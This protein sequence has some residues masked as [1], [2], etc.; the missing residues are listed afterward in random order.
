MQGFAG[1]EFADQRSLH[2][3]CIGKALRG[4][5]PGQ[6]QELAYL[7]VPPAV[8]RLFTIPDQE[9]G[10][11]RCQCV[12]DQRKQSLPLHERG[13]LELIEKEV[14]IALP[15]AFMD[16]RDGFR[17]NESCGASRQIAEEDH[18]FIGLP[19]F[20]MNVQL[21]QGGRGH[22]V[23]EDR[24]SE[25]VVLMSFL[26]QGEGF[27]AIGHEEWAD[28]FAPLLD[29]GGS[30]ARMPF[31]T[32]EHALDV[33][34]RWNVSPLIAG[35]HAQERRQPTGPLVEVGGVQTRFLQQGRTAPAKLLQALPEPINGR[36]DRPFRFKHFLQG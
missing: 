19:A 27:Q 21:V 14:L 6:I 17:T 3:R 24:A 22:Q 9:H 11:A 13:I 23:L 30:F 7:P 4:E 18:P 25:Q 1:L 20:Q 10:T 15:H 32:I 29:F 2:G 36:L 12:V 26:D 33:A 35:Q 28:R 5:D 8:D 16:E 34:V 31:L